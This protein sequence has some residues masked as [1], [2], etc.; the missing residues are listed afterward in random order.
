MRGIHGLAGALLLL[1]GL[2][3]AAR[4]DW[5]SPGTGQHFLPQDLV[6]LSGGTLAGNGPEYTL[7]GNLVLA[8][9]DSLSL[10]AGCRITATGLWEL[11]IQGFLASLGT[12]ADPVDLQAAPAQPG[13]WDGLVLDGAAAGSALYHTR[14]RHAD[15]GLSVLGCAPRVIRCELSAN[16]STGLHCFLGGNPVVEGTR[17]EGN[18]RYGVE[19]TG[20]SS[21]VLR[22]CV[23]RGNNTEGSAARNAVS[24]GIQ[25]SNSPVL[26]NCMQVTLF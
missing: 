11:R 16:F 21:P 4:A 20:G 9:G 5:T 24:V 3:P 25:G 14:V 17:I 12:P 15:R 22:R 6:A 13:A 8:A 2:A 1:T 19:I 10:P 26:E 23:I 18:R 7:E